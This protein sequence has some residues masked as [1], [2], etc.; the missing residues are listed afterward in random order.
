MQEVSRSFGDL[1]AI[2]GISLTVPAGNI[3]GV[4]G[5]SGSGKTT[6]IRTLTGAVEPTSGEVRVLGEDPRC[7]TRHARESIGYMPQS[8]VL[9]PDLTARENVDFSGSLFGMLWRR[10]H[11]RV[12][13]VL[14]LVDLWDARSRRASRLSGGMQRRLEL[15]CTLVHEPSLLFLDEPTAGLDPLLRQ[16]VWTELKRLRG[17]GRTMLVTTQYVGEAEYCDAV[18]MISR[19]QL[20]A[21]ATPD[22]LRRQA[23]GGDVLELELSA[24]FDGAALHGVEGVLRVEQRGDRG[25]LITVADAGTVSPRLVDAVTAQGGDVAS[26]REFR[27]SYDEIFATLVQR[28]DAVLGARGQPVARDD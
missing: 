25:L 16:S 20:I 2:D 24:P 19:G 4:I 28:H 6:T 23:T 26:S 17:T 21:L 15:A 8:F 11:H 12:R 9:Y 18:A 10:R 27:P 1:V 3:L 5:P 7:F 22:D 14:E 13:E